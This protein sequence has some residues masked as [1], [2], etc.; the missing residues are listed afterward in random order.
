MHNAAM[1]QNLQRLIWLASF[2]KS[3][4]TWTRS[5]LGN[6]L[7]PDGRQ[8]T[9][10][11]LNT[12][13]TGDVRQDFWDAAWGSRYEG[14]TI[15]TGLKLRGKVLRLIAQSKP[16]MHFAKTHSR[17]D[18]I[19]G[20]DLIPPDVTAAA[21]Y[22]IRNP[23][24][25]VLSYSRHISASIDETIDRMCDASALNATETQIFELIGRW[26]HHVHSWKSAPG[27][28]LFFMRYED[29]VSQTERTF[30]ALLNFLQIPVNDGKLRRAIRFSSFKELQ[31]QERSEGFGERP[32]NMQQFFVSGRSGDWQR[33]LSAAQIG[34]ITTEFGRILE[35]HYPET[36]REVRKAG[37]MG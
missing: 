30:R 27:L 31:K 17:I 32:E 15:E 36:L 29:M 21:I 1:Q 5:F 22:I 34:R 26:D 24:D 35:K 12:F 7:A 28:P 9:I 33:E 23:F 20:H 19:E 13:T 3:G 4:N 37:A 8:L 6:Y 11:Q 2:P 10:N 25:V 14:Q 18:R 16:Q